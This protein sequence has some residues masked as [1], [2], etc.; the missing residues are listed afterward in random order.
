MHK[1][2]KKAGIP[3]MRGTEKQ[4]LM[5]TGFFSKKAVDKSKIEKRVIEEIDPYLNESMNNLYNDT[6]C[7]LVKSYNKV[8]C[9]VHDI[10]LI[11]DNDVN[12]HLSLNRA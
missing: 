10:V 5:G 7:I 9:E 1:K 6:Y 3:K 12:S 8:Y 11:G 4:K 2:Y